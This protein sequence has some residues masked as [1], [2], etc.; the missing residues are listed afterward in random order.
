M[1]K[2][3]FILILFFI[4]TC[5][6]FSQTEED[7][8]IEM[9][10]VTNANTITITKTDTVIVAETINKQ[11]EQ[12]DLSKYN[13]YND[14][15]VDLKKTIFIHSDIA[16]TLAVNDCKETGI[17]S[18]KFGSLVLLVNAG[19]ITWDILINCKTT[20]ATKVFYGGIVFGFHDIFSG[21]GLGL[22]YVSKKT[23]NVILRYN[24]YASLMNHYK[25]VGPGPG[26]NIGTDVILWKVFSVGLDVF[27]FKGYFLPFLT[28]GLNIIY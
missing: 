10:T 8:I 5:Y 14:Y 2:F 24:L 20:I 9:Y 23:N 26:I 28:A 4:S 12:T 11:E 22:E 25:Q 19:S 1:K 18:A 17:I 3:S 21:F 7:E 15:L 16:D 6:L 27:V 13:F